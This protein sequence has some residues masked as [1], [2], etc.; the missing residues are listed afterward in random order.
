MPTSICWVV[1]S[2]LATHSAALAPASSS[3]C[4]TSCS[5]ASTAW[6]LFAT[7]VVLRLPWL[8]RSWIVWTRLHYDPEY[9]MIPL[10]MN[11][12]SSVDTAY[13]Y[14]I[15]SL[16]IKLNS[17]SKTLLFDVPI[18]TPK[19]LHPQLLSS[20]KEKKR[21]N[22]ESSVK[23]AENGAIPDRALDVKLSALHLFASTSMLLPSLLIW[24][25]RCKMFQASHP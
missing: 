19:L 8:C 6:L 25:R 13:I 1:L 17:M 11:T 20:R 12:G 24:R 21:M 16:V 4:F 18:Q 7:V 2:L 14:I 23:T 15:E 10:P 3:H 22:V 5:P 9:V